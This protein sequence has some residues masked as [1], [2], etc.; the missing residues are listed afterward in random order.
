MTL[1]LEKLVKVR[2]AASR[3]ASAA[4]AE[5]AARSTDHAAL[6]DRIDSASRLLM[7]EEGFAVGA[8]LAA[9]LE[10]AE[11]MRAAGALAQHR[12]EIAFVDHQD[13]AIKRK[14]A[15]RALDAAIDIRRARDRADQRRHEV[16][17]ITPPVK[18][19]P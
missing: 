3:M 16:K 12:A 18:V 2:R 17:S 14:A 1:R 8:A 4:F 5:S 10:L 15:I 13:A 19:Q 11:R 7:P 9:Q 6:V